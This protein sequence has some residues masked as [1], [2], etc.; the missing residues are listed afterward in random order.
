[1]Y[2]VRKLVN[3]LIAITLTPSKIDWFSI[4][5]YFIAAIMH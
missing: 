5:I 2:S 4:I 3:G 1:M